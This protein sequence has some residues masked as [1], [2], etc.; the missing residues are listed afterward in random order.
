MQHTLTNLPIKSVCTTTNGASSS[1][2]VFIIETYRNGSSWYRKYSD[3]RIEQGGFTD[4]TI[5]VNS[6]G[7]FNLITPFTNTNY[8][9][10][11][12]TRST[13]DYSNRRFGVGVHE[14]TTTTFTLHNDVYPTNTDGYYWEACGI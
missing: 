1:N 10:L 13:G 6:T 3:G 9:L 8:C 14:R 2:P 11:V 7:T 5:P 4:A 12:M